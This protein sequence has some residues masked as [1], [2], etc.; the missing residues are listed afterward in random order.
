VLQINLKELTADLFPGNRLMIWSID[1]RRMRLPTRKPPSRINGL[2]GS[3]HHPQ[4]RDPR[5]NAQM[6]WRSAQGVRPPWQLLSALKP[7]TGKR[8]YQHGLPIQT[9]LGEN[10]SR[11][12]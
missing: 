9:V 11:T 2:G 4:L 8:L 5:K 10:L 1:V 3:G 7:V 12:A 6:C